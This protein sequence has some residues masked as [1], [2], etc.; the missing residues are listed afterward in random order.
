MTQSIP[1]V[2]IP[3]AFARLYVTLSKGLPPPPHTPW[4]MHVHGE[5]APRG[6]TPYPFIQRRI[7]GEGQGGPDLPYQ[8]PYTC[9]RLKFLYRKDCISL[10]N[11]LILTF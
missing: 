11:W 3:Q 2:S 9:L 10:F 5:T 8:K 6:P 1:S 7:Q 4:G